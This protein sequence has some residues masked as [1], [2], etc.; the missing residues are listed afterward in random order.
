MVVKRTSLIRQNVRI[1]NIA[2]KDSTLT[3]TS[4]KYTDIGGERIKLTHINWVRL[5]ISAVCMKFGMVKG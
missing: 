5:R 3:I 1:R 4:K 2:V